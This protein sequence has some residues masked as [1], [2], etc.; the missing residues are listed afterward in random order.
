MPVDYKGRQPWEIP[1][2]GGDANALKCVQV[3]QSAGFLPGPGREV[4]EGRKLARKPP[5]EMVFHD[6]GKRE[7]YTPSQLGQS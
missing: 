1:A 7:R 2:A 3:N 6:I 4:Y 5:A